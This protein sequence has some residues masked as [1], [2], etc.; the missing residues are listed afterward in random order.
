MT[1]VLFG[2]FG[3]G[4]TANAQTGFSLGGAA[5]YVIMDEGYG[6]NDLV[7]SGDTLTGNIG[8]GDPNGTTTTQLEISGD[9]LNGSIDFAGGIDDTGT[10]GDRITGTISGGVSAV[11]ADLNYLNTLS[12]TLAGEAGA[13]LSISSGSNVTINANAGKLDASGNYVFNIASFNASG[14]NITFNGDNLGH[15]VVVN[16]LNSAINANFSGSTI[17]LTGGLTDNYLLFNIADGGTLTLSGDTITGTYL[18][19]NG[20]VVGSGSTLTGHVYGGGTGNST[21]SGDTIKNPSV[22]PSQ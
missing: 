4:Q 8:I 7:I 2:V 14:D 19:P 9:T 11:Q 21:Y 17:K 13:S 22:S 15:N 18:D 16:F 10:S 6:H 12:S 20:A 1:M 5:N 3:L